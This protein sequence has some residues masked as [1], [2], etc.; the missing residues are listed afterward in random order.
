MREFHIVL[1]ATL[2]C[3]VFV[4][5]CCLR[6]LMNNHGNHKNLNNYSSECFYVNKYKSNN[7]I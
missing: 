4:S 6:H 7:N 1:F 3:T 5:Q 2:S